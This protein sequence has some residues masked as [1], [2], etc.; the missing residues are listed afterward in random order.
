[1]HFFLLY[2]NIFFCKM[3]YAMENLQKFQ[4][5]VD[6][7]ARWCYNAHIEF[8]DEGENYVRIGYDDGYG[9]DVHVPHVHVLSC[10][11][12][13]CVYDFLVNRKYDEDEALRFRPFLFGGYVCD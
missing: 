7:G 4:K 10:L 5:K 3:Q 13:R 2:S 1:M 11:K 12:H 9:E 8:F 6:N